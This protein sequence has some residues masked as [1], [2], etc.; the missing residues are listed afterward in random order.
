MP[1]KISETD[2]KIIRE[3]PLFVGMD[4]ESFDQIVTCSTVRAYDRGNT[5]F[6]QGEDADAFFVVLDGWLKVFR[7]RENGEEIVIEIFSRGESVAEAAVF[8]THE[9]PASCQAV[10]N[11]RVLRIPA[12]R[13]LDQIRR[14]PDIG[15][16]MLASTSRHLHMLIREIEEIRGMSSTQRVAQFL[17]SLGVENGGTMTVR[18][19]FEKNLIANRLAMTPYSL[20]R[21]FSRLKDYGVY[22]NQATAE[23]RDVPALKA[24]VAREAR[25]RC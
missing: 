2:Y 12:D 11:C 25:A 15:I 20:S 8:A 5:V 13:L 23:I 21:A 24:L 4:D 10:E 9:Y 7:I 6:M 17:L 18:M 3:V 14:V 19:P 1:S 16:A 22:I